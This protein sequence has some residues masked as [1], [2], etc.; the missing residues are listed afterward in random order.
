MISASNNPLVYLC[1]QGAPQPVQAASLLQH[2][3]GSL[4]QVS[5]D[6]NYNNTVSRL[7]PHCKLVG[8]TR[9]R[10]DCPRASSCRC[11]AIRCHWLLSSCLCCCCLCRLRLG[12]HCSITVII[13]CYDTPAC[14]RL[15]W[16]VLLVHALLICSSTVCCRIRKAWQGLFELAFQ[17]RVAEAEHLQC[18]QHLQQQR[19]MIDPAQDVAQTK[20]CDQPYSPHCRVR[21]RRMLHSLLYAYTLHAIST[22]L[23]LLPLP[24]SLPWCPW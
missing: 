12:Y 16:F 21:L 17:L 18:P 20:V 22:A 11:F 8:N 4:L 7:Q 15:K 10:T 6:C 5:P 19:R 1:Y 3:T 13:K 14:L 23:T 9:Y 24:G 2:L